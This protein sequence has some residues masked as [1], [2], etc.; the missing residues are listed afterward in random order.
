LTV[1]AI[2][3]FAIISSIISNRTYIGDWY[4][5]APND[6]GIGSFKINNNN[7]FVMM[8]DAFEIHYGSWQET[9]ESEDAITAN[10][11]GLYIVAIYNRNKD[12]ITLRV[13]DENTY[14]AYT[15]TFNRTTTLEW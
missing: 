13:S 14:R 11:N 7:E 2:I 1:C 10:C 12:T 5:V 4:G 15:G 6:T 9:E 8:T 3:A